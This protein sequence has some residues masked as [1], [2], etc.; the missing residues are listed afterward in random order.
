[1]VLM[2]DNRKVCYHRVAVMHGYQ[3][4]P[5][6]YD[7]YPHCF[8]LHQEYGPQ[9]VKAWLVEAFGDSATRD[10]PGRYLFERSTIL[11]YVYLRDD[12]DAFAFRMRWC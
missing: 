3:G 7:S 12:A 2:V 5:L 6:V 8:S 9:G 10:N 11:F 1:V 4:A